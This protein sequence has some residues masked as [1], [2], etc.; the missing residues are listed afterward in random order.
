MQPPFSYRIKEQQL[1]LSPE[2]CIF[3]EEEKALV[4]SDLHFGKTGH[5]R[6]SGIAVPASVYKE[7]LHRLLTQI[8]YFQPKQLLIVGDLFHSLE[9]KEL[10]L[11]RR[12]RED[13]SHL[14]VRLIKGNHDILEEGWYGEAGILVHK[15]LLEIGAFGFIHDITESNHCSAYC[16]SGHIHPGVWI[17]GMG[18]QAL[19]FPCFYFGEGYAVLPAFSRFTGTASINAAPGS[20]VFAI[21]PPEREERAFIP[22]GRGRGAMLMEDEKPTAGKPRSSTIFQ[23]Q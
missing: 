2:R 3:W 23:I 7:D 10:E 16:F 13:L 20:N 6:K 1:W 4:L 21:L 17:S 22:R 12:W 9:N 18:K 15:D 19:R 14:T 5:F 11:F 8:Q